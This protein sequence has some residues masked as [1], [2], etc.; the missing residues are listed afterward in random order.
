[1]GQGISGILEGVV[2]D[3]EDPTGTGR[4]KVRYP[5]LEDHMTAY[6]VMPAGWPGA[7]GEG[8][9]AHPK[10]PPLGSEVI[11]MYAFGDYQLP[12]ARAYYLSGWPGLKE[13]GG[14]YG[15]ALVYEAASAKDAR[16]RASIYESEDFRIGV[17]EESAT[18][19]KL[20]IQE[21]GHGTKIEIDAGA[22]S[23][24]GSSVIR[25][26]A[27]SGI[28]IHA[29]GPLVLDSDTQV[30]IQGRIVSDLTGGD[31]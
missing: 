6:W 14:G 15:A 21:K 10:P 31:I 16:K 1:M 30:Q 24:G 8:E 11:V 2:A 5:G 19:K 26:E 22:G 27:Q 20:I 17:I 23:G 13:G 9:G 4:I 28:L 25:I 7:G 12:Q 3:I 18:S 29:N